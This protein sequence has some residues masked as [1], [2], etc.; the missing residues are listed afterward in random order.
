MTA[1]PAIS[2]IAII[3][4]GISAWS[5]AALLAQELPANVNLLVV[6]DT[7]ASGADSFGP[8]ISFDCDSAFHQIIGLHDAELILRCD[9]TLSLGTNFLGWR[10]EGSHFLSAPSAKLPGINGI[11]FHHIVL[12]A[13]MAR[14]EPEKLPEIFSAFRFPARAAL[15]GKLTHGTT[16]PQSPRTMLRP[17]IT[18]DATLYAALLKEK[19]L[20]ANA[21]D[22]RQGQ[23]ARI[24]M[25]DDSDHIQ[26]VILTNGETVTADLYVDVEGTLSAASPDWQSVSMLPFDRMTS[27]Q[28]P[29][30]SQEYRPVPLAQSSDDAVLFETALRNS[31]CQTLVYASEQLD[32]QQAQARLGDQ[33]T[34]TAPIDCRQ[35]RKLQPWSANIVSAGKAAASLGPHLSADIRLLHEQALNLSKLIPVS[36]N[37]NVEASEYNRLNAINFNQLRDFYLLP[38][39]LN[40]RSDTLWTKLRE[41]DLPESLQI[42]LD[43][44][45]SRGRFVTF[46]GELFEEQEWIDMMIGFGLIPERHDPMARTIDMAQIGPSLGRMVDAFKQTIDAMPTHHAY[47]DQLLA[48]ATKEQQSGN[49]IL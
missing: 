9:G 48:V 18:L 44:F 47:M 27:R 36:K 4:S 7:E 21:I 26:S 1:N 49:T 14:G 41:A 25:Q 16:D 40:D 3:G 34:S 11:A 39:V 10:G 17:R 8:A 6:E 15:A 37:M 23:V 42:R 45:K 13:A 32:D 35:Q 20:A 22:H 33:N 19:M 5:I 12:R 28:I 46:D 38:F 2:N 24:E 29:R 30:S 43:Q 31:D